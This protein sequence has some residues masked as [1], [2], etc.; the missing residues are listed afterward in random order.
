MQ[1]D[2]CEDWAI[3][4]MTQ[5]LPCTQKKKITKWQKLL[6][7]MNCDKEL[8]SYLTD[9]NQH[10]R[11]KVTFKSLEINGIHQTHNVTQA[12]GGGW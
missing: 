10:D 3:D 11:P 7:K 12:M 6:V 9:I 8:L 2:A 1:E 5:G 4:Q